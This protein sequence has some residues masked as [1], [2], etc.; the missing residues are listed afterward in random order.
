MDH[1]ICL[2]PLSPAERSRRL[3][4]EYH[5]HRLYIAQRT[6]HYTADRAV[7]NCVDYWYCVLPLHRHRPYCRHVGTAAAYSFQQAEDISNQLA[8]RLL[9]A[10]IL[11]PLLRDER[12][13]RHT[14]ALLMENCPL[15]LFTWLALAKLGVTIALLNT[16][17]SRQ[18]LRQAVLTAGAKVII[19]SRRLRR[20]WRTA[21]E[22]MSSEDRA[23]WRVL[24]S[25]GLD[26]EKETALDD[27]TTGTDSS[28][29]EPPASASSSSSRSPSSL[30]TTIRPRIAANTTADSDDEEHLP[31]CYDEDLSCLPVSAPACASSLRLGLQLDDPLLLIFTS[32]TTGPS[33]AAYFSHRRF[34]GAGVTWTYPMQLTA[35]DVYYVVL[36]LF[37][38]NAGVVAVSACW[39]TGC[40][41]LLRERLSVRSFWSDVRRGGVTAMIHVGEVWRYLHS[42][43][44]RPDDAQHGLRVIAGNG[45]QA[46]IWAAVVRRFGIQTVVEHFGCTEMPAGPL[47]AWMGQPGACGFIPPPVRKAQG[48]DK[49]ISF[50]VEAGTALRQPASP[51]SAAAG[52]PGRC[53][54]VI[55]GGVGEC[56][57]KL[58]PGLS[59]ATASSPAA[60]NPHVA[61]DAVR[62]CT[63][64]NPAYSPYRGYTDDGASLGR[65]YRHVFSEWD[66]WFSTGDLLR[67]DGEGFFY[68]VDRAAD[69]FR[70]KGENVSSNDVAAVIAAF[71][72]VAQAIVYGVR[73]GGRDGKAGMASL[74]LAEGEAEEGV[75]FSALFSHCFQQL[76]PFAIP[77]FLRIVPRL[78]ATSTSKYQKYRNVS[79]G[80]DVRRVSDP[81]YSLDAKACTFR[82]ITPA[83]YDE[84]MQPTYRGYELVR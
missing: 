41:L 60:E 3:E 66:A 59:E 47:M 68:F 75:D 22:A 50:D 4:A 65:V 84:L 6:A 15:F 25:L 24:Y 29:S 33:K 83:R 72:A 39:N 18:Q 2:Q 31:D 10:G 32:G 53:L 35:A 13:G 16:S 67:C 37:H 58:A 19:V 79:E 74:T 17:I 38:G 69:S 57:F 9:A 1:N 44:E 21:E 71:P 12:H 26:R 14:A 40:Q 20:S 23:A 27:A 80:F 11:S 64:V 7:R 62:R 5:R 46:D 78:D 51:S 73:Y 82:R 54:E 81:L 49:L 36:P 55:T 56:V 42:Q 61:A 34:L 70:W 30:S 76:A 63:D 43:P 45:L 77:L 52:L 28:G 48:A 8:H